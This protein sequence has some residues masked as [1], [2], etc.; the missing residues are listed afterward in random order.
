VSEYKSEENKNDYALAVEPEVEPVVEVEPEPELEPEVEPEVEPEPTPEPEPEV[1]VVPEPVPTPEPEVVPSTTL[2]GE[3]I[4]L[5]KLVY[6]AN[7][8]N[9]ASVIA[10]KQRLVAHGFVEVMEERMGWIGD[11]TV[12]AVKKFQEQRGLEVNGLFNHETTSA[13]IEGT[14]LEIA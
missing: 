10:V 6:K 4:F 5:N 7:T 1:A 11:I 3:P 13:L 9:S 14:K 8:R 12:E 2:A